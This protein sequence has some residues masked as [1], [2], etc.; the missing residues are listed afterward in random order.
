[1][2]NKTL[3]VNLFGGPSAGKSTLASGIFF[4]LKMQGINSE[5]V[6]E[7]CKELTWEERHNTLKDQIYI[8]GQQFH[9]IF[10][11][12]GKV[13]VI[14]TDSPL[15]LTPVYDIEK[16]ES[17]KKLA[18][19]EHKKLWTYN[20]VIKRNK[21]YNPKGRSQTESE[22]NELDKQIVDMLFEA[23]ECFETF[24]G[25]TEG[26]DLIVKKILKLL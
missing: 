6:S 15:L 1:M 12:L 26:K 4:D 11:L 5:L 22:A 19:E 14:I 24:N 7:Y 20:V 9:R 3:I 8:F 18:F 13:D 17:L 21:S 16:R 2:N 23:N 10:R 25:D